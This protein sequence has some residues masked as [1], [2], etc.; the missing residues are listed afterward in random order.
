MEVNKMTGKVSEDDLELLAGQPSQEDPGATPGKANG[1]GKGKIWPFVTIAAG[2][3]L[4]VIT[5]N[6]GACPTSAC[7]TSCAWMQK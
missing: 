7:T 3:A 5:L 6:A 4:I 1:S 2:A